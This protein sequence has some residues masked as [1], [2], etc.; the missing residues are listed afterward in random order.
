M[1]LDGNEQMNKTEKVAVAW[2]YQER[3]RGRIWTGCICMWA[4]G[5]TLSVE[6]PNNNF[7]VVKQTVHLTVPGGPPHIPS[8]SPLT[9][10]PLANG[11][12]CLLENLALVSI[13]EDGGGSRK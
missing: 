2:V 1:L 5:H 7:E 6:P 3:N 8:E 9:S 12:C 10:G 13:A 4:L 11:L